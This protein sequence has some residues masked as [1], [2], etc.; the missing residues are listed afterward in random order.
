MQGALFTYCSPFHFKPP[1]LLAKR[2][3]F[4]ASH[5][6]RRTVKIT[7]MAS[8]AK[9]IDSHLHVWASPEEAV[10]Q[11]PYFPGQEPSL[12]GSKDLLLQCMDDAGVDGALIVQPINHMFDHSY[13]N[14]VL[15]RYPTKFVGCCLA[16]PTEDGSGIGELEH[17]VKKMTNEVGKA[18]FAKSGE[19][20]VPVGFMCF[21]GLLLHILDIEA[22][23]SQFPS[24]TVLIDHFGFCKPPMNGLENEAWSRLL[25]LSKFPQVYVKVSASFRVSRKLYPYDDTSSLLSDLITTFGAERLMW[26]SD[27]PFVVKE[28]GYKE[29][30]DQ[31]PYLSSK[32]LPL[33]N[34]A[35]EWIMGKTSMHLFPGAWASSA[36]G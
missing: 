27:F 14:S 13:V 32:S 5:T 12:S 16:N 19:L 21:K 8:K 10:S 9:I 31:I 7:A 23:C 26:G 6:S 11:Y 22:L 35:L 3:F 36:D 18:M 15:Q 33:S 17:L 25:G 24:T 28:C 29:A 30:R 34:E 20:G 1:P 4:L 2:L